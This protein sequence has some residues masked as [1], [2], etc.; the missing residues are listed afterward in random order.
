L[1]AKCEG[2]FYNSVIGLLKEQERHMQGQ[3]KPEEKMDWSWI[4][5]VRT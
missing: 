5:N 3:E 2:L 4:D 1:V